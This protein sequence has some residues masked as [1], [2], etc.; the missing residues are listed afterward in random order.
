[1]KG[2]IMVKEKRAPKF[3]NVIH[4]LDEAC[5]RR[6][7]TKDNLYTLTTVLRVED[8]YFSY[9]GVSIQYSGD[10]THIH[11]N[12]TTYI[13][14]RK[15]ECNHRNIAYLMEIAMKFERSMIEWESNN[16]LKQ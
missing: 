1:M 9:K 2:V 11:Y 3:V 16:V 13:V 8:N 6:L 4:Y 5:N 14:K 15:E 7:L 12:R 10:R